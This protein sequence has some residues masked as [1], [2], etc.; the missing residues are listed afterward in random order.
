MMNQYAVRVRREIH[1]CPELGFALPKTLALV[2]RELDSMGVAYRE[3]YGESS[4]VATI[5]SEK[6]HFT[7]GLRADMDALPLQEAN[8]VPY[9]SKIDGQMHACGHDAHTAILLATV[10][11]LV[12]RKDEIACCVK[13]LF[14]PA[15]ESSGGAKLMVAGGVMEDIDCILALH[16]D[17]TL[18]VGQIAISSGY[19]NAYSDGFY[20]DFYGKSSHVANQEDGVDAIM[21]AVKAYMAMEFLI[22]KEFKASNPCLLNV[23]SIHGGSSNN[24]IANHCRLFCTLRTHCG[25]DRE[26]A[27]QRIQKIVENVAEESGGRGEYTVSKHYPAVCNHEKL[28]QQMRNTAEKVLGQE[29][30]LHTGP[31]SMIGEDFSY[32]AMEK[33]GCFF[34]LGTG[35][36]EKGITADLHQTNFDIDERALDVGV[37]LLQQFVY[38]HMQ[39]IAF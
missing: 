31:R 36:R 12:K 4:I 28:T 14:Q 5:N 21:M 29:N 24:I 18:E 10:R 17:N 34:R 8:D 38:D 23:G 13:F 33:P 32:F 15:E 27:I 39:G 30:V 9:R 1:A 20:L 2:R 16:C 6:N 11:E 19:Q 25:E 35:N 22:A 26:K 37:Q 7:I 3:D